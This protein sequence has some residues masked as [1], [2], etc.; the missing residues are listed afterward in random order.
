MNYDRIDY[1]KEEYLGH[2]FSF[3]NVTVTPEIRT[4]QDA[5]VYMTARLE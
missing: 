2:K 5:V 1:D 4:N 3:T